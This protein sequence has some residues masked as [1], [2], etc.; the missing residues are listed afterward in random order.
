MRIDSLVAR[1][2]AGA[3]VLAAALF[4]VAEAQTD[5][6]VVIR[7]GKV[8]TL[9]GDPIDNGAIVIRSGRISEVG[10][11][12]EISLPSG[13][14]VIDASGLEVFPGL[15]DSVS[16]LGMT[17]IGSTA[18]TVDTVELGDFN[19]QLQARTAIHP[20]SEH[21]PVARANGITHAVAVPG[22]GRGGSFGIQGQASVVNL[23]GW[24]VEEMDVRPSVGMVLNWP[25]LSTQSFDPMTFSTRSRPFREVKEEY[26]ER[27]TQLGEWIETARRYAREMES[28]EPGRSID[29]ALEAM[30]PVVTG[31]LPVLVSADEERDIRNAVT[32]CKEKELRMVLLG[33]RDSWKLKELLSDENVPVILG[34]TL[35]LP[36]TEDTPYDKPLTTAAELQQAGVR[37]VFATFGSSNSRLLPFEVGNAVA[38]GLPWEEG[39]KGVTV[40]AA[41]IFGI[42]DEV[43]TIEEGKR[44]NLI[45][46]D[47]DP[48]EIR[49]QIKG[50]IIDGE[51]TSLDNK[52][53]ELY[54]K[55][56]A[57][58]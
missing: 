23:A 45:L 54:E 39:L 18:A 6:V 9:A 40:Y 8:H 19:P 2:I 25:T 24:T 26:D 34:P 33:G 7:G 44:A 5:D 17:E 1:A 49:T 28:G 36:A 53:L 52:H 46:T 10:S 43:G 29:L 13:A 51:S 20:A 31:E 11:A 15:M 55:Y 57:R 12:S 48:L 30:V 27:V 35:S 21:I 3:V 16:Q 14:N 56:K 47:G 22:I 37:V 32:F 4:S 38:H 58:P 42:G 41:E 50:L